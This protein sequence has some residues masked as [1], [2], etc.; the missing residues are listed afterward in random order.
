MR[1]NTL[2]HTARHCNDMRP[3]I[4]L[5]KLVTEYNVADFPFDVKRFTLQHCYTLL[6]TATHCTTL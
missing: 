2:Q 4:A 5:A 1:R 3:K 6:H